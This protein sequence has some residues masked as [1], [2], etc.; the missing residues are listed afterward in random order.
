LSNNDGLMEIGKPVRVL[1]AVDLGS[2]G[3]VEKGS[4]GVLVSTSNGP[5][6]PFLVKFPQGSFAFEDGEIEDV[7]EPEDARAQERGT[8]D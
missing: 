8:T 5:Y 1:K 6:M 4:V 3:K 7:D 2:E